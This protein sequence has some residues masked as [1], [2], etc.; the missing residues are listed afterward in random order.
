[1]AEQPDDNRPTRGPI[2]PVPTEGPSSNREDIRLA[3]GQRRFESGRV[4]ILGVLPDG[5][6]LVSKTRGRAAQGF[7]S[8]T[9]SN[10]KVA[11]RPIA[12]GC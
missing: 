12:P 2:P 6:Q 5:R 3:S 10:G 9:P 7:D 11:E 8:S 1:M 4:H